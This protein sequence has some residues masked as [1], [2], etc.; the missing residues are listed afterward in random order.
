MNNFL[1]HCLKCMAITAVCCLSMQ[2]DIQ[3]SFGQDPKQSPDATTPATLPFEVPVADDKTVTNESLAAAIAQV[4]ANGDLD[5]PTKNNL[6]QIYNAAQKFLENAAQSAKNASEYERIIQSAPAQAVAIKDQIAEL[7]KQLAAPAE[8]QTI[9]DPFKGLSP[10]QLRQQLVL[11]QSELE[12]LKKQSVQLEAEPARRMQRTTEFPGILTDLQ[13]K[14]DENQVQ[15]S[16]PVPA[17]DTLENK[18]ARDARLAAERIFLN[19]EVAKIKAEQNS[20]KVSSDFLPQQLELSNLK[21][22]LLQRDIDSIQKNLSITQKNQIDNLVDQAKLDLS[23]ASKLLVPIAEKNVVLSELQRSYAS[24]ANSTNLRLTKIR[25]SI[26]QVDKLQKTMK[27]RVV[28]VGLTDALE[29][30]INQQRVNLLK[31]KNENQPDPKLKEQ[32][33]EIQVNA[34]RMQDEL[35]AVKQDSM[36]TNL[37]DQLTKANVENLN[38]QKELADSLVTKQRQMLSEVLA[39]GDS[40]LNNLALLD[41][42]QRQLAQK[43]DDYT[44]Y[45]DQRI[46]WIRNA[47][48]LQWA[49][50]TRA[51]EALAWLF[52]FK[53]VIAV[54]QIALE[55][56]QQQPWLFFAGSIALMVFFGFHYRFKRFLSE[57][58]EVAKKGRCSTMTPTWNALL[59]TILLALTW[60]FFLFL[61]GLFVETPP[62]SS[63]FCHAVSVALRRIAIT[64]FVLELIRH[65]CKR[66]GLGE[67]HFDWLPAVRKL[68]TSNLRWYYAIGLPALGLMW[69]LESQSNEE[70]K[71]SLGRIAAVVFFI[72]TCLVLHNIFRP[73]GIFFQQLGNL[74]PQLYFFRYFIHFVLVGFP[75]ALLCLSVSGYH[76]TSVILLN[77]FNNSAK[78]GIVLIVCGRVLLRW[79]L[80]QRRSIAME[81][82]RRLRQLA[83]ST[84]SS[85]STSQGEVGAMNPP[86]N[87]LA[88]LATVNRQVREVVVFSISAIGVLWFFWIWR[89]ALPAVAFL[90][91]QTL[92]TQPLPGGKVDIVSY[93]DLLYAILS[94]LVTLFLIKNMPGLLNLAAQT[95]STLDSGTRYAA[96]TIVRYI[97]TIIGVVI[98]LSF[99]SIPWSQYSWLVAAATVGIGFGLQE[100]IAN[101]VSGLILLLERPVRVGDWV[102]ID[103]TTGVVSRIQMRATTVTNWDNQELIVPNKELI[104]GKLLNWTLSTVTTRLVINV[105]VAMAAILS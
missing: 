95:Y 104:T 29:F 5:E 24:T 102:T 38:S 80:M 58:N 99:L 74:R 39:A 31:L 47:A 7:Q 64:L 63:P 56:F 40:V 1:S 42:E 105:G 54:Q 78:A 88:E 10:E 75:L 15:Q 87:P 4:Q 81:E 19:A 48:P 44:A 18:Q 85:E 52:D 22:Q 90:D 55:N 35:D 100:I 53:N 9:S 68:I 82:A 6:T 59:V 69:A 67:G 91:Q 50:I 25:E 23:R 96:T 32:L 20:Y 93:R 28:A 49:D 33:V 26:E 21:I 89:D 37:K 14:I 98:A 62:A 41:S 73:K 70:W 101:F 2:I 3:Q 103:G 71:N 57:A 16:T 83:V 8:L 36:A 97:I 45:I 92:W 27:D 51:R 12:Q 65:I 30:M 46:V 60:P 17:N 94:F 34:F 84:T 43:I 86:E 11:K 79:L 77:G 76:Y 61:M 72:S 13:K 66:E